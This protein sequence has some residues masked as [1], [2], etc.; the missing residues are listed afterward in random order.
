MV[1]VN[2]EEVLGD[3]GNAH[4]CIGENV[5]RRK[6]RG[7][8]GMELRAIAEEINSSTEDPAVRKL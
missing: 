4:I 8:D 5:R 6:V 1:Y 2:D 3:F 7:C